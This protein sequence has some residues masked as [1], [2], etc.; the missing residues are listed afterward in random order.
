M[1]CT[2]WMAAAMS[3]LSLIIMQRVLFRFARSKLDCTDVRALTREKHLLLLLMHMLWRVDVV[4][5]LQIGWFP[6]VKIPW[7]LNIQTKWT[8]AR[9]TT[10]ASTGLL[11]FSS[12]KQ[13]RKSTIQEKPQRDWEGCVSWQLW[14]RLLSLSDEQSSFDF[15]VLSVNNPASLY[16]RACAAALCVRGL[17]RPRLWLSPQSTGVTDLSSFLDGAINHC[18]AVLGNNFKLE[19]FFLTQ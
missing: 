4:V 9:S 17:R 14:P 6:Q 7:I 13:V 18:G 8:H 11:W 16:C 1:F 3:T 19:K 15:I 10:V 5:S 12:S 2:W